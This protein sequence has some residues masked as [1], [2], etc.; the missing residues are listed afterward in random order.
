MKDSTRIANNTIIVYGQLIITTI[1]SLFV[2]R[3]VL[4]ALGEEDYGIYMLVAGVVA[5]LNMFSSS[6]SNTAMRYMGHSLGTGDIDAARK[7]F[8]TTMSLHIKI[9]VLLIVILEIGGW[10]MFQWFLNIPEAKMI[11]SKIVY[12]FM[13]VTTFVAIVSVPYDAVINAHENLFFLSVA[14]ILD[15]VLKLGL[16][17]ILLYYGGNR[18]IF[19][20]AGMMIIQIAIR[21]IKQV[22][23]KKKYDECALKIKEHKDRELE[24]AILSFT[25]WELFASVAT[26]CQNQLRGILINMFFGVRLNASEGIGKKV[27][28]HVNMA[29][30]GI[31]KAITPQMNK[32]EG[33]G[34]RNRMIR[35]TKIGV[36]YTTFMFA[37]ISVPIILE[38]DLLLKVWL[39]NV[40]AYA[41][42]FCQLCMIMQ[43]IDKFTWQIGN[44]IRAVGQNREL[45]IVSGSL[46][47]LGV[48]IAYF[49]FRYGGGPISIYIV[50]IGVIIVLAMA[51]LYLGKR[52]VGISPWTFI[53]DAVFPVLLPLVISLI[54]ALLLHGVMVETGVRM[55]LV[56]S[57]FII[58]FV[59][60]FY[61]IGMK[62][63]ERIRINE[64]IVSYV[65]K[66]QR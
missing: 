46:A 64:I 40:P 28:S 27:N 43:L 24:R 65:R 42:V 35:I 6:L 34:D 18:L 33:R 7:T 20:G 31:T 48:I 21:I 53:K 52:I 59:I 60:S 55:L 1:I 44:A 57:V 16:A 61:F 22:Y 19:Y 56:F 13:V 37:L 66:K 36:K 54:P 11:S 14:S 3:Y 15:M 63:E 4:K 5:M 51:R 50:E 49:V 26:I 38:A 2:T 39:G 45:Q 29:S 25:G 23:S 17:I 32:S 41:V 10:V 47:I 30:V 8:N 12:Q 9:G 62:K 58:L